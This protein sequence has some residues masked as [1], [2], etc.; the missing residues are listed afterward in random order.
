MAVHFQ[1]KRASEGFTVELDFTNILPT[2]RSVSSGT[3]SA[4][5]TSDGSDVSGT[6][7]GS[8]TATIDSNKTQVRVLNGSTNKLYK[9]VFVATL[10]NA[11]T[12]E[13]DIYF[14]VDR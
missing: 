9:A 14:R 5:D 8:T 3:V 1:E 10:D 12:L 6:I 2:G 7:L 4:I 11:D 13:G